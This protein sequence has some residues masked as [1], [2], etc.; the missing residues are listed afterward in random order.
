[1]KGKKGPV[2][3]AKD[4][5]PR[6]ETTV[7]GLKKLPKV[8]KKDGVI[9][10]GAASGISDGAGA[11]RRRLPGLRRPARASARSRGS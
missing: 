3:F 10:A 6:P 4:E 5:H 8:F 2:L 11:L 1:M 7:E 9:H